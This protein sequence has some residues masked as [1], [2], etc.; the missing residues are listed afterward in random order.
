[1]INVNNNSER[2]GI[3]LDLLPDLTPLLDVMFM[4]V[5]FLVLTTNTIHQVFD[6][7]LPE[8]KEGVANI[9]S[10]DDLIKIT[11]FSED[12]LWAINEEKFNNFENF[13]K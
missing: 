7:K 10:E 9:L 8:D 11:I 2:E 13:K 3:I 4:L 6:V 1:M 12:N 5:I